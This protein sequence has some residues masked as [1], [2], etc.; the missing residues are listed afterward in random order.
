MT[1]DKLMKLTVSTY[2]LVASIIRSV[3]AALAVEKTVYSHAHVMQAIV[4]LYRRHGA[5]HWLG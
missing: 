2:I 4:W 5:K 3:G 1:A